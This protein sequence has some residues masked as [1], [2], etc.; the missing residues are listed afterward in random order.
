[1]LDCPAHDWL[2]ARRIPHIGEMNVADEAVCKL[3]ARIKQMAVYNVRKAY[4]F[5]DL[6]Y[7]AKLVPEYVHVRRL[8]DGTV[9]SEIDTSKESCADFLDS[10]TTAFT[11]V[12]WIPAIKRLQ[13]DRVWIVEKLE[14]LTQDIESKQIYRPGVPQPAFFNVLPIPLTS[15]HVKRQKTTKYQDNSSKNFHSLQDKFDSLQKK[16]DDALG[17]MSNYMA[18]RDHSREELQEDCGVDISSST[19]PTEAMV[20]EGTITNEDGRTEKV[21]VTLYDDQKVVYKIKPNIDELIKIEGIEYLGDINGNKYLCGSVSEVF[22]IEQEECNAVLKGAN[23]GIVTVC[24]GDLRVLPF[25][26]GLLTIDHIPKNKKGKRKW[27]KWDSCLKLEPV[28]EC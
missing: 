10:A 12:N 7:R 19:E 13:A 22:K 1:M 14:C 16:Y 27:E 9:Q 11:W 4:G 20:V 8:T 21:P 25:E 15:F 2:D 17:R 18:G 28:E 26:K 24:N 6:D 23:D 3:P 5:T